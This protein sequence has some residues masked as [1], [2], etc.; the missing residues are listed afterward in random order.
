MTNW[1]MLKVAGPKQKIQKYNIEDPALKSF[2]FKYEKLI[3]WDEIESAQNIQQFISQHML[4]SLYQKIDPNSED[5][6]YINPKDINLREAIQQAENNPEYQNAINIAYHDPQKAQNILAEKLNQEKKEIFDKW[7][8]YVTQENNVYATNPAFQYIILK[9]II[10]HSDTNSQLPTINLNAEVLADVYDSLQK[11]PHLNVVKNYSKKLKNSYLNTQESMPSDEEDMDSQWIKIPSRQEDPENYNKNLEKLMTLS[12]GTGWCIAGQSM[13][14]K[15]LS[16]GDFYLYMENGKAKVAIRT[17]GNE[18]AEIQGKNNS[19]PINY[20]K[21]IL[22]FLKRSD[23]ENYEDN[24]SYLKLQ[25]I[26]EFNT[27]IDKELS[28]DNYNKFE[29]YKEI[30]TYPVSFY[31]KMDKDIINKHPVLQEKA[32]LLFEED[33]TQI[34]LTELYKTLPNS[35]QTKILNNQYKLNKLMKEFTAEYIVE[36]IDYANNA[37]N[38][39][40]FYIDK[41]LED[42]MMEMPNIKNKIL[43][44]SKKII[45]SPYQIKYIFE[46]FDNILTEKDKHDFVV[47]FVTRNPISVK[48]PIAKKYLNENDMKQISNDLYSI[49]MHNSNLL[50]ASAFDNDIS[51]GELEN[52][53]KYLTNEQ[54]INLYKKYL[55]I[56]FVDRGFFSDYYKLQD[57]IDNTDISTAIYQDKEFIQNLLLQSWDKNFSTIFRTDEEYLKYFLPQEIN[58]FIRDAID[59]EKQN[60]VFSSIYDII[61]SDND[62]FNN[63][64][65]YVGPKIIFKI[66]AM[67][68]GLNIKN[69]PPYSFIEAI[70]ILAETAPNDTVREKTINSLMS[71]YIDPSRPYNNNT[72]L[73][74]M[75]KNL[76][77]I[78]NDKVKQL[79]ADFIDEEIDNKHPQAMEYVKKFP[80]LKMYLKEN[81]HNTFTDQLRETLIQYPHNWTQNSYVLS[82]TP[83]PLVK[84]IWEEDKKTHGQNIINYIINKNRSYQKN[85]LVEFEQMPIYIQKYLL[86]NYSDVLSDYI[87]I[88]LNWHHHTIKNIPPS[89]KHLISQETL[90][91]VI[92]RYKQEIEKGWMY[93]REPDITK[94]HFVPEEL[95]PYLAEWK[96]QNA[97]ENQ[98]QNETKAINAKNWFRNLKLNTI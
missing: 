97:I 98:Q 18:L 15:Y 13:A 32:L 47:D 33:N 19:V 2:I 31:S 24:A 40:G 9:P 80:D 34:S 22:Q 3:P 44:E 20:W 10:D 14:D 16:Q 11:N 7:W 61:S 71:N 58:T 76:W 69:M 65:N 37:G 46:K 88:L 50:R 85:T 29:I 82:K 59:S 77:H 96:K 6:N 72:L 51:L 70:N 95:Y 57:L 25:E 63:I 38:T 56:N 26:Y 81:T 1:Y 27:E 60:K 79:F 17:T 21:E 41:K 90:Q 42:K 91:S 49:A 94:V 68:M 89:L 64:K 30:E 78:L 73:K 4:P 75:D 67:R 53:K 84:K 86:Q 23:I 28:K 8:K 74:E 87:Q 12:C 39:E 55:T 62:N 54:K 45:G 92:D 43:E 93:K 5:N 36:L 83:E 48:S 35:L 52:F 66:V